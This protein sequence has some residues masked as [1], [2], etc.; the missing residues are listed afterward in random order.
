MFYAVQALLVLNNVSFSKHSQVKGYFNKEFINK[1]IFSKKYGKLFNSVFEFRQK[2]D[3]VDLL[4]PDQDMIF[5]YLERAKEFVKDISNYLH[6]E[7]D[8]E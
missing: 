5:D 2:F 3:Y 8:M 1:G 4:I 7:L 6:D